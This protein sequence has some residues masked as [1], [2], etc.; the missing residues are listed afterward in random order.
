MRY[1]K[2]RLEYR[3]SIINSNTTFL[4]PGASLT[5]LPIKGNVQYW[6]SKMSHAHHIYRWGVIIVNIWNDVDGDVCKF[7]NCHSFL[8]GI[9]VTQPRGCTQWV[10]QPPRRYTLLRNPRGR[11]FSR[12]LGRGLRPCH[13]QQESSRTWRCFASFCGMLHLLWLPSVTRPCWMLSLALFNIECHLPLRGENIRLRD[14]PCPY[15]CWED[16][17]V[18]QN[19]HE[20]PGPSFHMGTLV[21]P[22]QGQFRTHL[23]FHKGIPLLPRQSQP[24]GR[25]WRLSSGHHDVHSRGLLGGAVEA[26][27]RVWHL[28][29]QHA[30]HYRPVPWRPVLL[31][32]YLTLDFSD[33][34]TIGSSRASSVTNKRTSW[35]QWGKV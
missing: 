22:R 9:C 25:C 29:K 4:L 20:S 17:Y 15:H 31:F 16:T 6:G 5:T 24:Q 34:H 28:H 33:T 19:P 1:N 23:R 13:V 26:L 30:C 3:H 32:H 8:I 10:P 35:L 21:L 7:S 18:R 27:L 14:D 2:Q 12:D 11:C